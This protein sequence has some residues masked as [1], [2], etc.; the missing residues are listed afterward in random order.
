VTKA[1][2]DAVGLGDEIGDFLP[3]KA[4]DLVYVRPPADSPLAA[5]LERAG[6]MEQ[7]LAAIFTLAGAESIREVRIDG[8]PVHRLEHPVLGQAVIR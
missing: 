1:G 2:A 6:S 4:A 5:V 7:A 8:T 3:G